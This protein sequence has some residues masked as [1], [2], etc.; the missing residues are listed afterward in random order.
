[1]EYSVKPGDTLSKIAQAF[2]IPVS[3]ILA[4]N[5][6]IIN[7][8]AIS[9]G[10]IIRIPN[11]ED[12]PT[13]ASFDVPVESSQLITRAR[14][15]VNSNV[16]YKLGSGGLF[17]QD[18]QPTRDGLC[19]CSGFISW[20]LGLS[21]KTDIP[22]YK[23][24]GGWIFTDSMEA[25]VNSTSG[26]FERL[27]RPEPGC[28]VVYG[29]G[30]KIGH[31]GLVSVVSNGAMQKV[32]HCSSGNSTKFNQAIL[33]TAPTVFNRPDALWGRFVG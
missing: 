1:M 27:Q 10:Q 33:E 24:F 17:P 31:V 14:S 6:Q 3:S 22:F 28:I 9:V 11:M 32:I 15:A 30:N 25:D 2:A 7:A 21:R 23:K 19:D 4:V 12:V 26:I 29:A 13:D 8:N 16:L 20:V 5:P 18:P